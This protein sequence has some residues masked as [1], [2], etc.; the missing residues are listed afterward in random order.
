MP[1]WLRKSLIGFTTA[2]LVV[3]I[4][5]GF[6]PSLREFVAA[7]FLRL[8]L[9]LL[10]IVTKFVF[11]KGI[12]S[13]ATIA[14]KRIFFVGGAALFKRFW[15]NFAKKNAITH[16]VQPLMPHVKEWGKA[17]VEDFKEKPMWIKFSGTTAGVII[18]TAIGYFFGLIGYL[19]TLVEKVLTGKFQSFFLTILGSIT[20]M[21]TF[22]WDKI[23]PW[24]D[25]IVMTA[26]LRFIEKIPG[27]KTL[28]QKTKKVKDVV[29]KTKDDTIQAVVHKPVQ[30]AATVIGNHT[31]KKLEQ[32]KANGKLCAETQ[33]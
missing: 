19:F 8:Y 23:S 9:F 26:V 16:V 15:I 28:F 32:R 21:F 24:I 2:F 6:D 17:H 33:E 31:K 29:V 7:V 1:A 20:K 14:W 30:A 25:I 5:M 10:A 22:I 13:V 4:Y 3:L 11:Q 12:V 18:I 27:I